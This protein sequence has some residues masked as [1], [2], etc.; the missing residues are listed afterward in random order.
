[1]LFRSELC[2]YQR[3]GC[4]GKGQIKKI[5]KN[6]GCQGLEVGGNGELV[7]NGY[8]VSVLQDGKSSVGGWW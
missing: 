5:R 7:F 2:G 4:G 1:M 6:G 3:L 8:R